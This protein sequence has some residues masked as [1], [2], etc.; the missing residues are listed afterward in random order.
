MA[1]LF[2]VSDQIISTQ[3][4]WWGRG[5]RTLTYVLKVSS[6]LTVTLKPLVSDQGI[7][8]ASLSMVTVLYWS[9]SYKK[10]ECHAIIRSCSVYPCPF[11][12]AC[13]A[14]LWTTLYAR[15]FEELR[16]SVPNG[17]LER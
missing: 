13:L 4:G 6:N 3:V 12:R 17:S 9:L 14:C 11:I 16:G 10:C 2:H 7:P 15:L 1:P 8:E 5:K